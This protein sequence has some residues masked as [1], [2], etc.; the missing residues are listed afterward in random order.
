MKN[1]IFKRFLPLVCIILIAAVAVW[2]QSTR[3]A[4]SGNS[5]E[6]VLSPEDALQ[7]ALRG[8]QNPAYQNPDME[9]VVS[10]NLM[11]RKIPELLQKLSTEVPEENTSAGTSE[12][13]SIEDLPLRDLYA[14]PGQTVRFHIY[15]PGASN[16]AWEYYDM[17]ARKWLPAE[18]HTGEETDVSGRL[19][20]YA[21]F[22]TPVDQP[23][24]M[25]RCLYETEDS[26][27][28]VSEI[29]Y[30]KALPQ[31]ISH[32]S[33]A[34]DITVEAGKPLSSCD[35]AVEVTYMDGSCDTIEGLYGLYFMETEIE[36]E[37]SE[38]VSIDG[39]LTER[40]VQT[41]LKHFRQYCMVSSGEINIILA[42]IPDEGSS[43]LQLSGT[44]TGTDEEPPEIFLVDVLDREKIPDS[45]DEFLT[46]L[47][48]AEDNVTPYPGLQYAVIQ[49][50]VDASVNDIDMREIAEEDWF[51]GPKAIVTLQG[52][53]TWF[54]GC[55][56][57]AGNVSIYKYGYPPEDPKNYAE[58]SED[59]PEA[60]IDTQAPVIR[61]IYVE[62]DEQ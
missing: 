62:A 7:E 47:V 13:F 44:I 38:F 30:L 37:S 43:Q 8:N 51:S 24:L 45:E 12:F 42:Y 32:L 17:R 14:E 58:G 15:H 50:N 57:Q 10:N 21:D 27:R 4:G 36:S 11:I 33:L 53:S 39:I 5:P 23:E 41:V 49:K 16:H 9:D 19:T 31:E 55:R 20:A 28:Q 40:K 48:T 61:N 26:G 52:K 2:F 25:I 46:I 3:Q 59:F 34:N 6:D 29:A 1:K 35:I 60:E 54:L 18:G 22:V 56:D